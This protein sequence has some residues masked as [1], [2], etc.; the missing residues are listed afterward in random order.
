MPFHHW[1]EFPDCKVTHKHQK[2]DQGSTDRGYDLSCER[3]FKILKHNDQ[4]I[5]IKRNDYDAD[6][7][8]GFRDFGEVRIDVFEVFGLVVLV[9]E[10]EKEIHFLTMT[11]CNVDQLI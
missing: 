2:E 8:T 9:F 10:V 6:D 5:G 7:E 4:R 11:L 1:P 3:P